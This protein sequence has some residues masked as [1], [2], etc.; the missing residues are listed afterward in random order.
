MSKR[1]RKP[2]IFAV[3][4]GNAQRQIAS[5]ACQERIQLFRRHHHRSSN[6]TD[7]IIRDVRDVDMREMLKKLP[8]AVGGRG[9]GITRFVT[10]L[11]QPRLGAN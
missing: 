10:R 6:L 3:L 4:I 11:V 9:A 8:A 2:K 7:L 1:D 5:V